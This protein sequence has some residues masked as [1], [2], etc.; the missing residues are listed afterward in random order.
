[1]D[2]LVKVI[3]IYASRHGWKYRLVPNNRH[4]ILCFLLLIVADS[5]LSIFFIYY[6]FFLCFLTT[7]YRLAESLYFT[8]VLVESA[9]NLHQFVSLNLFCCI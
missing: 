4:Y 2:I 1:M 8:F 9:L 5:L 7:C 3:L 6:C